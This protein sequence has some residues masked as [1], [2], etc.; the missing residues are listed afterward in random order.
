MLSLY[1]ASHLKNYGEDILDEAIAFIFTHL[2]PSHEQKREYVSSALECYM[3]QHGV[4]KQEAIG[5]L[6]KQVT[7]AWKDIN[8]EYLNPNKVPRPL[9]T[10][11]FN[12]SRVMD[13]L[14]KDRDGYT[15]SDGSTKNDITIVLLNP[16]PV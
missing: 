6:Y 1:E 7:S 9:L 13:V 5:E 4:T 14:Y 11:V 8:E 2:S 3:K 10:V 15:H 16:W 12:L